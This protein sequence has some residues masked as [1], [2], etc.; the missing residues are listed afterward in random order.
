[1]KIYGD[2]LQAYARS[3][4]GKRNPGGGWPMASGPYNLSIISDAASTNSWR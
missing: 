3:S 4:N 2:E 1:M